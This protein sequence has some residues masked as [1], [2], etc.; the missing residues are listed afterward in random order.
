MR[1]VTTKYHVNRAGS[2]YRK[3]GKHVDFNMFILKPF[4]AFSPTYNGDRKRCIMQVP[5]DS[6]GDSA[7]HGQNQEREKLQQ[8]N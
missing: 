6:A 5:N 4:L 7:R 1:S 8:L 3:P 2:N